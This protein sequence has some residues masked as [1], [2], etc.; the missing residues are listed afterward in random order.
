MK[1]LVL[2]LALLAIAKVGYQEYMVRSATN[3][4]IVA[5]YRDRAISACQRDAGGQTLAAASAWAHPRSIK[6]LIGKNNLDVHIWQV[7]HALW[8]A[9]YR[10][11]Y[12]FL[13]A[14]DDA[15]T[16]CEFDIVHGTASVFRM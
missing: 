10:N 3:E 7:D 13:A 2:A 5:A 6:V 11:P 1:T 8:N 15:R 16:F 9:R 4:V 14:G 12:L